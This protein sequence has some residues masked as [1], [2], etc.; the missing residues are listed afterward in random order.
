M[1]RKMESPEDYSEKKYVTTGITTKQTNGDDSLKK[2]ETAKKLAIQRAK[3]RT[4]AKRQA[5]AEKIGAATA[6]LAA[7][8]EQVSENGENLANAV[9][10]IAAAS[11]QAASATQEAIGSSK[12]I[13]ENVKASTKDMMDL[14]ETINENEKM[15]QT[16]VVSVGELIENIKDIVEKNNV[17][18]KMIQ[19]LEDKSN[20]IGDIVKTVV[21]I[22]DQTN[23]LALNAAI[24][25]ARAGEHGTGFA[26]VADEVRN[27][28]EVSEKS[29]NTIR[30]VVD[31]MKVDIDGI[32]KD[33]NE[34]I[35]D[36]NKQT[37]KGG[38]V[39][40]ALR[41]FREDF[42][43]IINKT[44]ENIGLFNEIDKMSERIVS[45]SET[46]AAATEQMSAATL[47][48]AKANEEQAKALEE[49]SIATR[50]L[51]EI[52]EELKTS[53]DSEKSAEIVA[54]AAEQL[55]SNIEEVTATSHQIMSGLEQV[56]KGTEVVAAGAELGKKIVIE[57]EEKMNIFQENIKKDY[58]N[59][60]NVKKELKNNTGI[61]KEIAVG[62]DG[63][64]NLFQELSDNILN[65]QEKGF[66]INKTVNK[67]DKV[68][69]Q[70]NMLAVNGFVEAAHAGDYGKGFN[71]VSNDIRNLAN[72]SGENA[73]QIQE[74]VEGIQRQ[75]G[76]TSVNIAESTKY[77]AIGVKE[78]HG[79][80]K[81]LTDMGENIE[82]LI[83]V[84]KN[85]L[86]NMEIINNALE[87]EKTGIVQIAL[88]AKDSNEAVKA[89]MEDAKK[90]F[91]TMEEISMA[92]EDIATIADELQTE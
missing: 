20:K 86:N 36:S 28:A 25:A 91:K 79:T 76:K 51:M 44:E 66:N 42:V 26:V 23:L 24:E 92:I 7:N 11:H 88:A 72:D 75:I 77:T 14:N 82:S 40:E 9:E 87:E 65:L 69:I 16:M 33:I 43:E 68:T 29:A 34:I 48:S 2:R 62:L 19:E 57:I 6:E 80:Q 39:T 58:E 53:T 74:L 8:V 46:V 78:S 50:E 17:S 21:M 71:V 61:I 89:V 90:Q 64:D 35:N 70:T 63:S 10:K 41:K 38:I 22:S 30:D 59:I 12:M 52:A 45:E 49:I 83:G 15:V 37:E 60:E 67:I 85:V 32:V 47:E 56:S 5:M 18:V 31:E 73:D 81:I 13:N 84:Y 54:S 4:M 27:L 55:S 3:A 1:V